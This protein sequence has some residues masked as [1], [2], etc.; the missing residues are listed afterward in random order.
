MNHD[1]PLAFFI[2]WTVYG[3]FLQG[4]ER[5]WRKRFKGQQLPQP[6]LA[7]WRRERLKHTIQLLNAQQ[8]VVVEQEIDR[9]GETRGWK[10]WARSA[11][12]NHVHAVVTAPNYSGATVRDQLKANAT[13]GLREH[14]EVF[15]GRP[16]WTKL[17]DWECINTEDDLELVV[18]YVNEAQDRMHLPKY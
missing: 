9:H 1:E 15:H 4:D 11:R 16:V 6:K 10:V 2:T 5:G 3:T 17:G 12:T 7:Q 18:R 14:W 8:Q 13:R